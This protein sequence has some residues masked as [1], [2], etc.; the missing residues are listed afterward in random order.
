MSEDTTPDEDPSEQI[1]AVAA[2]GPTTRLV[3]SWRI[4]LERMITIL[5]TD[6]IIHVPQLN[7]TRPDA[8]AQENQECTYLLNYLHGSF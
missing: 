6:F 3:T 7:S 2:I 5:Q 8:S 4:L 1:L